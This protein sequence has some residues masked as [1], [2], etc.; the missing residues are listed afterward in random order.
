[1]DAQ[2]SH[3]Q[4]GRPDAV[5][6]GRWVSDPSRVS[7]VLDLK[8]AYFMGCVPG[9]ALRPGLKGAAP[10]ARARPAA[11]VPA[12]WTSAERRLCQ[13]VAGALRGAPTRLLCEGRR[14][15]APEQPTGQEYARHNNECCL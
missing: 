1:M 11:Q 12:Q 4:G 10:R 13:R 14:C 15:G 9:G 8:K 5:E 2:Y 6:F 3:P 7:Q